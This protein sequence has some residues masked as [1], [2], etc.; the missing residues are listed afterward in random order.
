MKNQRKKL[1]SSD[2]FNIFKRDGFTCQYCGQQAPDVV[3]EIDHIIP[4]AKG[5]NC[6]I[7]NLITSCKDCNRGKSDKTLDDDTVVKKQL[8]QLKLQ[9][10]RI[11]QIKM[12]A[13]WAKYQQQE[14][15]IDEIDKAIQDLT[16]SS[17][18]DSGRIWIKKH[19][20]KY[21]FKS[22]ITCIYEAY[23]VHGDNFIE[24]FDKF[25]RIKHY[26]EDDAHWAYS[27]GIL[28]NKLNYYDSAKSMILLNEAKKNG[29][30]KEQYRDI[31][32]KV[33]NWTDYRRQL[34]EF[35][36]I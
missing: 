16:G 36:S 3:L 11:E 30:S 5:G 6:E 25:I 7:T 1:K 34:E 15:E 13:Q 18:S 26:S 4:V 28:K 22:V 20:K 24:E 17:L 35:N 29:L 31:V 14:P 33:R 8:H 2:R 19:V 21:G 32:L 9:Q 27:V 12:I 23:N 10:E